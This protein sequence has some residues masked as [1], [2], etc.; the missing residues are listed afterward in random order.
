MASS[1]RTEATE[2]RYLE[3]RSRAGFSEGC[4]LC[5]EVS[6]KEFTYWR[7]IH[8][9]YPYDRITSLHDMIIPKRHVKE[10]ELTEEELEEFQNIKRTS[11]RGRVSVYP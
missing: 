2:A 8:N 10:T 9:E 5:K 6:K 4:N 1:L 11:Y 7:I 3:E